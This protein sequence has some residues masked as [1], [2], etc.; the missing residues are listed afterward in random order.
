VF[1][2]KC[3]ARQ[4]ASAARGSGFA[5]GGGPASAFAGS[6][7][8]APP[9]PSSTDF[10][11]SLN[12]RTASLLCYLP[13]V[14]WIPAIVVLASSKYRDNRTVR[15][16]AFQ[17]LYLFVAWLIVDWFVSPFFSAMIPGAGGLDRLLAKMFHAVILVAWVFMLVKVS[18]DEHFRLPVVGDLAEKSVQEQG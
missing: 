13:V 12:P 7:T 15:F 2:G 16:H 5:S 10:A 18:R 3:G 1:C 11:A 6:S 14:G 9:S 17:G 4:P 8:Q